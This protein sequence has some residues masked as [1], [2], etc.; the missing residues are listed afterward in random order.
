MVEFLPVPLPDTAARSTVEQQ[1]ASHPRGV[2]LQGLAAPALWLAACQGQAP[3][4]QVRHVRACVFV[5]QHGVA[6]AQLQGTGLSAFAPEATAQQ[7]EQLRTHSSPAHTAARLLAAT[8]CEVT[9]SVQECAPSESIELADALSSAALEQALELGTAQADRD[10]D[11]GAD[12]LIAGDVG[13][14]NTTVAAAV[15]GRLTFTEPVAIVG[16]GSGITAAMWKTKVA[17]VRDA[18]FRTRGIEDP[19]EIIRR[20]GGADVAALVGYIARAAARRTPVLIDSPLTA[21]AAFVAQRLAPGVKHWLLAT[22]TTREPAHS[23]ALAALEL[24]PLV[25]TVTTMG[26][27][28]GSLSTLPLVFTS[29]DLVAEEYAA[30]QP[31]PQS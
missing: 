22:T 31:A 29:I 14:G 28:V 9:I 3:A 16:P 21:V 15:M 5:G 6:H 24:N 18:M 12:L 27:G 17:V 19:L 20:A 25:D 13:T 2:A 8:G 1:L 30:L 23:L 7:A 26:Q 10:I 11:A 4:Q